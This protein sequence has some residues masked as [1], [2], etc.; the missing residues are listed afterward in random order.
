M[1]RWDT[2]V[3]DG[4]LATTTAGGEPNCAIGDGALGIA[5]GRI[6]WVGPA[7]SLEGDPEALAERVVHG[8]GA[9]LTPG[10]VDCHTHLVFGGD[11]RDEFERR[12][13]GA[14]YEE[15]ARAGG[16]ILSTVR[17]TRATPEEAL[18]RQARARLGRLLEDGVTT[19]EIKSGYGL[20]T[21]TEMLMLRVAR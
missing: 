12:A 6:A 1:K 11:R 7:S 15:I 8:E 13:A 5:G 4:N 21:E 10:L 16:G 9:W 3:V 14:T 18:L 20:D 19:V 17:S 2:L